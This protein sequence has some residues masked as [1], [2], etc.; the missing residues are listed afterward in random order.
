MLPDGNPDL[1][2]LSYI[3]GACDVFRFSVNEYVG[4][5]RT[6]QVITHEIGHK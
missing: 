6:T 5:Q 1:L 2:G 3:G 4:I